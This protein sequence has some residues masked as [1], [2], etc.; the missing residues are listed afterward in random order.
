MELKYI[1]KGYIHLYTGNGKGKTT[2]AI[3]LAVRAVG[4]G[5]KVFIG[6]FVKGMHYAELDSLKRFPEIVLRQ[7]GLDCFIKNEPTQRDIDIA[8]N[9]LKEVSSIIEDGYF[10]MVILDELCIALYYKLFEIEKVIAILKSK[11]KLME[12]VLTGRYAPN[13]LIELAD[14][15][16]EMKEVKHYYSKGIQARKGIEY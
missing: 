13:E 4:A 11:P 7:Y 12:V 8:R 3:G 15:V 16:T 6:Q 1:E 14:L 10:D 9:G 5:K 2:A